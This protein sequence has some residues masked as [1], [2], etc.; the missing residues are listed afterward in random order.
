[1]LIVKMGS[2]DNDGERLRSNRLQRDNDTGDTYPDSVNWPILRDHTVKS[3]HLDL[4]KNC[5]WLNAD[6]QQVQ[7]PC[8]SWMHPGGM[9]VVDN[10]LFLPVQNGYYQSNTNGILLIDVS[11]PENPVFLAEMTTMVRVDPPYVYSEPLPPRTGLVAATRGDGEDGYLLA[12]SG[13]AYDSDEALIF[14]EQHSSGSV[15]YLEYL[16]TWDA[17]T[18]LPDG[19]DNA[20]RCGRDCGALTLNYQTLNFVRDEYGNLL[21]IGLD[22]DTAGTTEGY[23]FAK[24]FLVQRSGNEFTLTYIAQK[25][26]RLSSPN[27][28][29]LDAASGVYISPTGQLII[30]TADHDN[31]GPS[32]I[33]NSL[34]MGEFRSI[35]VSRTGTCGPQWRGGDPSL[36]LGGPYAI[37]ERETLEV[38]GTLLFI[39]PWVQLFEDQLWLWQNPISGALVPVNEDGRS[40]MMDWR[41]NEYGNWPNWSD[42]YDD[43]DK[44]D[45]GDKADALTWCGVPESSIWLFGDDYFVKLLQMW[46]GTG[47]N[48]VVT[49]LPGYLDGDIDSVVLLWNPPIGY[50]YT[51]QL[52]AGARGTISNIN[53]RIVTYQAGCGTYTDTLSM[54]YLNQD[55]WTAQTEIH[56]SNLAPSITGLSTSGSAVEGSEITLSVT[57]DDPCATSVNAVIKWGDG[58]EETLLANTK[59]FNRVHTYSKSGAYT[60]NVTVIDDEGGVGSRAIV[61]TVMDTTPPVLT[62]P[63]NLIWECSGVQGT[64]VTFSATAI[65]NTDGPVPVTCYPASGSTFPLGITTVTCSVSDNA[66]NTT[67]GIFTVTVE[68]TTPP[69]M[70]NVPGPIEVQQTS[71][72]GAQVDI[73]QP[74]VEDNCTIPVLQSDAPVIFPLGTTTVTFTAT[75]KVGNT[76]T[77]STTVTVVEVDTPGHM[78]GAGRI[79]AGGKQHNFAFQVKERADGQDRGWLWYHVRHRGRS[80]IWFVSTH[81]NSVYFSDDPTIKPGHWW[82]P[83]VDTA[84]FTGVGR[85]NGVPGYTFYAQATDAGEPGRGRDTFE[86]M[87]WDP[88]DT[89]VASISGTLSHGNIQ[90]HRIHWFWDGPKGKGVSMI[91]PHGK[92]KEKGKK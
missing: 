31:E 14:L 15:H 58:A 17:D 64:E 12:I 8:P 16:S 60:V 20:W 79:D 91:V 34:E 75:D 35:M 13:E 86:M 62:L 23:D 36:H 92:D 30:Y 10:V 21:L 55:D 54:K 83:K 76:S 81:I 87:I 44:L 51:W 85:F 43:L 82:K 26:L 59:V 27:M 33:R 40:L 38:D 22:N 68:D 73:P 77:A 1:L 18:L 45:F 50:Q 70:T 88:N 63:S 11:E 42:D 61:V 46:G 84:A 24:M 41:G 80:G 25:H 7:A 39:E 67:T 65:D 72:E 74:T 6:N 4:S 52:A 32:W 48:H 90:S 66:G 56:V 28:G 49:D 69:V 29:D 78:H 47:Q 89:L 2:R 57:W 37:D 71:L 3:I 5:T 53:A 9:Q 19:N